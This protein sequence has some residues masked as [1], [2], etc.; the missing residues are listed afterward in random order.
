MKIQDVSRS[1]VDVRIALAGGAAVAYDKAGRDYIT[2]ADGNAREPFAFAGRYSFADRQVWNKIDAKLKQILRDG[3]RTLKVL[4]AGCGPG[5]WLRRIVM[6]ASKLGFTKIEAHGID[7]STRMVELARAAAS[8]IGNSKAR[9]AFTV[10]D[11]T[12]RLPFA[13]ARFD[14]TLCLYGVLN[15]IAQPGRENVAAEL[16]RVTADTTFVTVRAVGSPP[17]IYVDDLYHASFYH[18]DNQADRMDIE[19]VGGEHLSFPSHLFSGDELRALFKPHI[20]ATAMV[21]LDVFHSRFASDPN[22][23]PTSIVDQDMFENQLEVLERRYAADPRFLNRAAHI[24]LVGE[25]Q[26][27]AASAARAAKSRRRS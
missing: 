9:V 20:A 2:Y 17:T 5:T 15:H 10:A 3:R 8:D 7:I 12:E 18:Q 1:H 21:G 14:I 22:W 27:C 25:R 24:L 11:I 4:D 6:S 13:D 23:N 16:C 19:L 26:L